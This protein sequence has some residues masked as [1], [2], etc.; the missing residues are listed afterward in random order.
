MP[1]T[2]C[3]GASLS[4]SSTVFQ[5]G[6]RSTL[7]GCTFLPA[8]NRSDASPEAVTRSNPPWFISVTISSEVA[9]VLTLTLQPVSFSKAVTQ[10]YALSVSPRSIYPGQATIS[11]SPSPS[12]IALGGS[13]SAT[14]PRPNKITNAAETGPVDFIC[15]LPLT[16]RGG[17]LTRLLS[18][19]GHDRAVTPGKPQQC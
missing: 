11:T 10:S 8:T 1:S 18:I 5:L 6:I 13:A 4:R 2:V 12:P 19:S 7:T 3:Q 9:A 14:P 15:S 16:R 17:T